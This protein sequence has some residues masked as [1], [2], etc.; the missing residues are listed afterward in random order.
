LERVHPE[1]RERRGIG[2]TIDPEYAAFFVEM[3]GVQGHPAILV[4]ERVT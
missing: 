2:V 4:S 3:I 1:R